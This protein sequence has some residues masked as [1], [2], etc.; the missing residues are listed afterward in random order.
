[1][2]GNVRKSVCWVGGLLL[3]TLLLAACGK[4]LPQNSFAPAGPT[5]QQEKD[6][7]ILPLAIAGA[8]FLLVEGGIVYLAL[9]FRHRKGR[10]RMPK[11]LHGNSRLE[12]GWTI[13]PAVL[14]AIVVVPAI[15]LIWKLDRVP[16]D[17]MQIKVMGYQ[18]WWGFQYLDQDLQTDYGDKGPITVADVLVIPAGQT[19]NL[20]LASE[21]GGARDNNNTPDHQVIHSFWAP[22][23]FGKQDVVPGPDG[24]DNHIV[25][26]A[27]AP[28]TY[29]GQCAEFCGLQHAIMKFRIVALDAT[30]WQ[31]W[32]T[33]HKQPAATPTDALAKQGMDLFL[34]TNGEGGWCIACHAVGGTAAAATAGPNLTKFADPNHQCWAGCLEETYVDG[35]PNTETL[36][37]WLRD[38]A[39]LKPGAK[40]PNYHL[41]EDQISAL[42]AYLYSLK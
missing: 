13:A 30:D 6:V 1:M 38:P 23:L 37:Q 12:I 7:L 24:Q 5:A 31:A 40:M 4:D 15:S 29:F 25:F 3:L 26:A 28:G 14:L 36:K 16:S 19:I 27:D 20:Q 42:V 9:K 39:S 22:R 8:I 2:R 10:D 17:A 21:G 33:N 32:V 35:Q 18:W 34:G 11:Q 41:S